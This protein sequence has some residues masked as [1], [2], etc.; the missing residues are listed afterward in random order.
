MEPTV[1]NERFKMEPNRPDDPNQG[2]SASE[3]DMAPDEVPGASDVTPVRLPLLPDGVREL[4]VTGDITTPQ[5]DRRRSHISDAAGV[6]RVLAVYEPHALR[7]DDPAIVA[8]VMRVTR[9]CVAKAQPHD[10]LSARQ[11]IWAVAPMMAALCRMLGSLDVAMLNDRNVELWISKFNKHRTNGW[12]HLARTCLRRVGRAANPDGWPQPKAIGRSPI[13]RPYLPEIE[14]VFRQVAEI[15]R[16]EGDQ[17]GR[18]WVA[19]GGCGAALNGVELSAAETGDLEERGNG[20]LV[21]LVRGHR[22]RRVP[23]RAGWTETVRQ[24]ALLAEER[25]GRASA[26]FVR[27]RSK[28]AVSGITASLDFGQGSLNLRR[29]RTTWLTAHLMAGTPLPDLRVLAGSLSAQTIIELIDLMVDEVD[30][31]Q[32][33]IEG[34]RA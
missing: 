26:R 13:A 15:P 23:I 21:I 6:E 9:L 20:R 7:N 33:V 30:P 24:A 32:A 29:A 2:E 22:P 14:D 1:G 25:D 5:G 16:A 11:M 4:P 3:P 8:E 34:L 10:A 19:G 17:A 31:E 28:N 12:R 27:S 18:L